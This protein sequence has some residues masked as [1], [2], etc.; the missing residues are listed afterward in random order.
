MTLLNPAFQGETNPVKLNHGDV[1]KNPRDEV[2]ENDRFCRRRRR[3]RREKEYFD[4]AL[5]QI[6]CVESGV[7]FGKT[8]L[9]A[10]AERQRTGKESG[11][12]SVS[13]AGPRFS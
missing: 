3:R 1:K 12:I 6:L 7:K 4:E 8:F 9:R 11:A 2:T 10:M 13:H 5:F